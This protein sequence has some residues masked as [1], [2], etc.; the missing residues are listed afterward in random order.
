VQVS[1]QDDDV[2]ADL[3]Q[4]EQLVGRQH[5]PQVDLAAGLVADV[6]PGPPILLQQNCIGAV[7]V[8][9]S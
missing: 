7:K 1:Q 9:V 3:L 6:G 5:V 2:E 4:V 8:S